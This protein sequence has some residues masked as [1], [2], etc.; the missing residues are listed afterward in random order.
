M[1][2]RRRGAPAGGSPEPWLLLG[3]AWSYRPFESYLTLDGGNGIIAWAD[4][5]GPS[6]ANRDYA[7][8][9]VA[10]RPVRLLSGGAPSGAPCAQGDGITDYLGNL[11]SGTGLRDRGNATAFTC[12]SAWRATNLIGVTS[13]SGSGHQ[14]LG[15]RARSRLNGNVPGAQLPGSVDNAAGL[16]AA[17]VTFWIGYQW[18]PGTLTLTCYCS[19]GNG[20]GV[21]A[22]AVACDAAAV[23][24]EILAGV[25]GQFTQGELYWDLGYARA[26]TAAERGIVEAAMAQ[27]LGI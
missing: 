10:D 21:A 6:D 4:E 19:S 22:A 25:P 11:L 24:G 9:V 8:A 27:R 5:L 16:G 15:N 18:D 7:Q 1:R 23:L 14:T 26:L 17:P 13:L 3:P 20:P 2:R 12:Y